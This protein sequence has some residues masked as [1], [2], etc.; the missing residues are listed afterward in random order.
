MSNPR[1][2][3]I[4]VK[5]PSLL[6]KVRAEFIIYRRVLDYLG[7]GY[8]LKQKDSAVLVFA[9]MIFLVGGLGPITLSGPGA[10]LV[11][12]SAAKKK[13]LSRFHLFWLGIINVLVLVYIVGMLGHAG[14]APG[15]IAMCAT[16]ITIGFS[17]VTLILARRDVLQSISGDLWQ[18]RYYTIGA[19]L[20]PVLQMIVMLLAWSFARSIE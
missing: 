6:I 5:I 10:A 17:L 12:V 7:T 11:F 18:Q 16:P 15:D 19:I 13:K 1:P 3:A 20:I 9:L 14:P 8:T 2:G 4:E